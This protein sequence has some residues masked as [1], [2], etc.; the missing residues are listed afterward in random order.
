MPQRNPGPV[1]AHPVLPLCS[2][3]GDHES[4]FCPCRFAS[5]GH[6]ILMESHNVWFLMAGLFHL[7]SCFQG[8]F[9]LLGSGTFHFTTAPSSVVWL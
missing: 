7:A 2:A 5:S 8:S 9:M 4:A 1:S 6:F 3:L